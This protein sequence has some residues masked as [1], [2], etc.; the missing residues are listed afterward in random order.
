MPDPSP[1]D[2][3]SAVPTDMAWRVDMRLTVGKWAGAAIFALAAVLG[4]R[5]LGQLIVVGL[6]AGILVVMGVRDL[7]SPVRLA[8]GPNGVTVATGFRGR[9]TIPW[10][11][12]DHIRVDARRGMLLRSQVLELDAGDHLYF[13][14]VNELGAPCE[15]VVDTL[16]AIR[17]RSER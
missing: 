8:A 10:A 17:S 7:L 2:G 14:S 12:V 5:D 13:F 3:D 4:F 6:A 11:E 15:E 1:H 16:A 9:R